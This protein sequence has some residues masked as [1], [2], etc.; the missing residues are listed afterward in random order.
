[1]LETPFWIFCTG[2]I[3]STGALPIYDGHRSTDYTNIKI[4]RKKKA[5]I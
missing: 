3:D 5:R 1:M 2:V 4:N